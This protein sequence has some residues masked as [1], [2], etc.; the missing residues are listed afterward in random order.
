M[1]TNKKG[2]I[3]ARIWENNGFKEIYDYSGYFTKNNELKRR[4][5]QVYFS[6]KADTQLFQKVYY[7]PEL[8]CINLFY[9]STL[10][11]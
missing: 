3:T 7:N 6:F 1:I 10:Y 2:E 8:L 11:F 9:L 5:E 4:A